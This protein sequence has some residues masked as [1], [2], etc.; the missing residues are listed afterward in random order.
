M[1]Y[2]IHF[3]R[4]LKKEY[5]VSY[6][7]LLHDTD[8]T[9]ALISGDTK[10]AAF[11]NNP[12][13]KR[14]DFSAYFLSLILVLEKQKEPYER[15]KAV[16]LAIAEEYVRPKNT[17]Q[18]WLKKLPV[19]LIGTPLARPLLKTLHARISTKDYPDGFV[20][21][22]I[23]DKKETYGLGYG[24][25]ILECGICKLFKRHH[26]GKYASILCEVDKITTSLAGLVMIRNGTIAGG[27][28]K[29]DFR[30]K[31]K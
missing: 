3:L 16:S 2:K 8:R 31:I 4:I 10:F 21:N 14:L 15:I 25:D 23:T 12:L 27:A 28:A 17:F 22:I 13:D 5:P 9:Y 20:A 18:R 6:K 11:S 30:Y 26:A 29:C 24:V 1:K 19:K 7:T